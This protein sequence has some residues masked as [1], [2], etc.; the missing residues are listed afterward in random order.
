MEFTTEIRFVMLPGFGAFAC[1]PARSSLRWRPPASLKTGGIP[2]SPQVK[3]GRDPVD[4][5]PK[6]GKTSSPGTDFHDGDVKQCESF[7]EAHSGGMPI[8]AQHSRHTPTYPVPVGGMALVPDGGW[9]VAGLCRHG[10][11]PGFQIGAV[12]VAC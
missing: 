5:P 4:P 2:P 12:V 8:V 3:N 7:I 10:Y 9:G 6:T 1:P 11:C